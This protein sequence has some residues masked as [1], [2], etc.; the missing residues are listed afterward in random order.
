MKDVRP[1]EPGLA[2]AG[3]RARV[4]ACAGARAQVR[5]QACVCALTRVHLSAE[6]VVYH[7]QLAW[8]LLLIH[9]IMASGKRIHSR[10]P[11]DK[12]VNIYKTFIIGNDV[13]VEP[14]RQFCHLVTAHMVTPYDTFRTFDVF[15]EFRNITFS[16]CCCGATSYVFGTR[17]AMHIDKWKN[18]HIEKKWSSEQKIY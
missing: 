1:I 12:R 7:S 10:T 17:F 14:A 9:Y 16:R 15:V 2:C 18:G 13:F 5:A 6:F 4:R 3:V 11:R 8:F